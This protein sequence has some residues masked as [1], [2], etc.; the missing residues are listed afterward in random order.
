MCI[1]NNRIKFLQDHLRMRINEMLCLLKTLCLYIFI[2]VW[3]EKFHLS[4]FSCIQIF[5]LLQRGGK[6][7]SQSE[8]SEGSVVDSEAESVAESRVT[9]RSAAGKKTSDPLT[10]I[11]RDLPWGDQMSTLSRVNWLASLPISLRYV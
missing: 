2:Y 10:E 1:W 5:F 7:T 8:E 11:K 3:P 4:F 9:R 6:D